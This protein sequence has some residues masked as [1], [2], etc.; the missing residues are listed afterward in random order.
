MSSSK[1]S[2]PIFA[3]GAL[4]APT[5]EACENPLVVPVGYIA[6]V[7]QVAGSF[8][9]AAVVLAADNRLAAVAGRLALAAQTL[10]LQ[11]LHLRPII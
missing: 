5:P 9:E 11:Q 10:Y 8:A 3:G 6:V 1:S 2:S 4:L 7:V